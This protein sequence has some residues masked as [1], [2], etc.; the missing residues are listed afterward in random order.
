MPFVS[1]RQRRWWFANLY[2]NINL[3]ADHK[4]KINQL[5]NLINRITHLTDRKL[6]I[7]EMTNLRILLLRTI[8]HESDGL[9]ARVQRGGGPARGISQ[10]EPSTARDIVRYVS[11]KSNLQIIMGHI[12][13]MKWDKIAKLSSKE[14]GEELVQSDAIAILMA[15]IKYKMYG[16]PIPDADDEEAQAIYWKK[17]YNPRG[18]GKEEEFI[19]KTTGI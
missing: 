14:L 6:G 18:K 7:K 4:T 11:K 9:T 12:F 3:K 8:Y 15:R 13:D 10:V 5:K 17:Y 19:E 1:D 2:Q 16:E